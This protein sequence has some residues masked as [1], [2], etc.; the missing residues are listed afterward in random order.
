MKNALEGINTRLNE[1]EDCI[2]ELEDG[3]VKI[4]NTEQ[5][6][7]K[8]NEKERKQ[9]RKRNGGRKHVSGSQRKRMSRKE[10]GCLW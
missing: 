9:R 5:K 10:S 8:K 2:R 7:R 4:T 6:K 1:A 3:R